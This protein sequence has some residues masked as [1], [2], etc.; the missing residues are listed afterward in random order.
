MPASNSGPLAVPYTWLGTTMDARTYPSASAFVTRR[1]TAWWMTVRGMASIIAM[2]RSDLI[3]GEANSPRASS[4][5][6]TAPDCEM[7][8]SGCKEPS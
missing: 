5:M 7:R 4:V 1:S 2:S 3:S 8:I 6:I